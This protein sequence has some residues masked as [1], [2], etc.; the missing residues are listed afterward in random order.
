MNNTNYVDMDFAS[1]VFKDQKIIKK[2]K[3]PLT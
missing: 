1:E 2:A 3:E